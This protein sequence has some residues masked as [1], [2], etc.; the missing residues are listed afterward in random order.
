MTN[1]NSGWRVVA[2][3]YFG[4]MVGFGSLL[5]FTFSIFLKPLSVE[6][7][8]SRE[9]ISAAFG[10]AALTV[11]VCSPPLGHLLD[12][13]GPRKIVLP[14]MAVFGV[15]FAS[16]STLTPSLAHLYATFVVIGI[17]GNGTTQMGYSRAVSTWFDRQ[18][19]LALSLV[20]AGVGTGA[21]LF[22]PLAQRLIS[23]FGWRFAYASLGGV[24]LLL[25]IPLTAL[26]VREKPRERT[27]ERHDEHG[28]TVAAGLRSRAFW[29]IVATLFLGSM[30]VNGAITHLSPL[31]TDR[32]ISTDSAA[33]AASTLGLASFCGRLLTGYLLDR[34]F[35]P[36]VGLCL[37]AGTAGGILLLASA[38]T[39][40]GGL[41]AAALI[42][43]G[44]G[45]EA[46]ITP[47][48]LTRYFGLR[49]FSTLYGFTWTAYAIAGAIGP[50]VMGRA[51]DATGSYTTLLTL[52]AAATL[53][54]ASLF[55]FLP[56]YPMD[57]PTSS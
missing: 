32:G 26:F 21:M 35:A 34:F 50:V 57:L 4:V 33:L 24:I 55:I 19:G 13:F 45:G 52:L 14:C 9:S 22:P 16:L 25:G 11:A 20:M 42:G 12:R 30:S 41:L 53:V 15:A 2:A 36:R 48:L 5:V 18:R 43:F 10:L 6:F 37:L 46:D 40:P 27:A 31:L 54:S 49:S 8:W 44:L 39:A 7:G 1:R 29:I 3:A 38:R 47:Y 28:V 51:F 17:V 56:R 23:G